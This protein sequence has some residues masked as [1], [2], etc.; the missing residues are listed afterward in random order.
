L[1]GSIFTFGGAGF[2]PSPED[3]TVTGGLGKDVA[4]A[5]SSMTAGQMEVAAAITMEYATTA[6]S[7]DAR[8]PL[9]SNSRRAQLGG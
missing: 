8:S 4:Y 7:S 1:S 2:A 6:P 9:Y 5:E 3:G